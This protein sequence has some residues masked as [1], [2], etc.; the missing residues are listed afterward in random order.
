[1]LNSNIILSLS[2]SLSL[3]SPSPSLTSS[4]SLFTEKFSGKETNE[5]ERENNNDSKNSRTQLNKKVFESV[6]LLFFQMVYR[7]RGPAYKEKIFL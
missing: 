3:F 6:S 7:Q 5:V 2:L 1:M 4:P